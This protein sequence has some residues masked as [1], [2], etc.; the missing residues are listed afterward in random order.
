MKKYRFVFPL[1]LDEQQGRRIS[2]IGKKFDDNPADIEVINILHRRC[3]ALINLTSVTQP[4]I[5]FYTDDKIKLIYFI[6]EEFDYSIAE[7]FDF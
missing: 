5:V 1:K 2:R 7:I 4:N 3:Q 6:S